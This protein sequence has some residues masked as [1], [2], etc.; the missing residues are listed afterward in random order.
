MIGWRQRSVVPGMGIALCQR[1]V[2][3]HFDVVTENMAMSCR[4]LSV[5][6]VIAATAMLASCSLVP[7]PK[8]ATEIDS[9]YGIPPGSVPAYL[10]R[11]DGLMTN[12]LLPA[13]PYDTGG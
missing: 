2:M 4:N 7:P 13:Q 8:T 9:Q 3:G 11:P 12:G 10:L 5:G 1:V 6:A